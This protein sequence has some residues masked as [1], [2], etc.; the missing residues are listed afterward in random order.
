MSD[1]CKLHVLGSFA[2][3]S[4]DSVSVKALKPPD[5]SGLSIQTVC[6]IPTVR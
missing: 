1:P 2:I 4:R 6:R 5:R 3:D